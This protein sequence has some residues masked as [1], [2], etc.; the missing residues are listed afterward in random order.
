MRK[1]VALSLTAAA[2]AAAVLVA[3]A[4]VAAAPPNLG[5]ALQ[6]QRALAGENPND[7]QVLNDLGNLL[8][9][10]GEPEE[11]ETAYRRAL[12][13]APEMPSAR[14]NLGL[15]LYQAERP[16]EALAQFKVVAEVE[17]DN[18][19][20]LYQIGA[21]HD[22]LG[23]ESKAVAFYARAFRLDPQLVFPEVNPHVI[24]NRHV[25]GAMLRAYRDLPLA[26]QA[27]KSYEQPG[28]IVNLMVPAT[29]DAPAAAPEETP[30]T[31]EELEGLR[32]R[33]S[34]AP[35]EE[36][37]DAGDAEDRTGEPG[38]DQAGRTLRE[39][40]LENGESVNQAV[41]RGAVIQPAP[42]G[43]QRQPAQPP[44]VQGPEADGRGGGQPQ[45]RTPEA[46]DPEAEGRR[47][48]QTPGRTPEARDPE[49]EGRRGGQTP[50]RT[51]EAR[52][53]E[54]EGRRGGQ[55]PGRTPE[56]RDQEPNGR[57]RFV[58]GLPST[59][60]LELELVPGGADE[61]APAG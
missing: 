53:P 20:A 41:P 24:D 21:A 27:P 9:L 40:D 32:P 10:A 58:P 13:I 55:T 1:T 29:G 5:D 43:G 14:Y 35:G 16:K 45:G 38:A 61:P 2:C 30:V 19:W 56:A 11:A 57:E 26:G 48:G 15:L 3:L 34:R 6:A 31:P 25:T 42:R 12:E 23:A 33:P 46:R 36:G 52:D 39:E 18:A 47:G 17:P 22:L 50:G 59:G 54:A 28:R 51:P 8:L 44:S 4:A 60:R 7:P 37:G 49:A